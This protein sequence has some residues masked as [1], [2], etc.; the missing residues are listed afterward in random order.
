MHKIDEDPFRV[1]RPPPL[2]ASA[3]GDPALGVSI[4]L[5]FAIVFYGGLFF[6][7]RSCN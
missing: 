7:L 5:V 2:P 3:E 4:A 6:L 1:R